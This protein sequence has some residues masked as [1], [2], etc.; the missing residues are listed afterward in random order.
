[1]THTR[2]DI[3]FVVGLVAQYMQTPHEIHWK[4]AKRILCYVRGTVQ[5]EI[6]YSSRGNPLLV[7]FTDADW[8]GDP[9]DWKSTASYVFSLGSGPITWACK[10]QKAIAL[11]LAE[12]EYQAVVN[13]SQEALWL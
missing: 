11:S 1:L 12:A 13:A 2:P 7:S 3:S 9:N 6:H 8:A 4:E 10:K 5:F